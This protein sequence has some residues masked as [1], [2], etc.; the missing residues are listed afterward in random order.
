MSLALAEASY[1]E[2]WAIVSVR[3]STVALYAAV[4]VVRFARDYTVSYCSSDV[5][6]MASTAP[7]RGKCCP[8]VRRKFAFHSRCAFAK[9]SLKFFQSR[10]RGGFRFHY[11]KS[12]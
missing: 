9:C 1:K 7:A 8:E 5:D 10:I 2:I 6:L 12:L 3:V 4:A 11:F